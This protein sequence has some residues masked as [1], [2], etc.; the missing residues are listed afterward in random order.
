MK[1]HYFGEL[2]ICD[3]NKYEFGVMLCIFGVE[4]R[5]LLFNEEMFF[6]LL[7]PNVNEFE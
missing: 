2:T 3:R 1:I 5:P 7:S 4:F 6:T